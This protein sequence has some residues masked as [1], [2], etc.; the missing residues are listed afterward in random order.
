MNSARSTERGRSGTWRWR[1]I[2]VSDWIN[3]KKDRRKYAAEFFNDFDQRVP[4]SI[5]KLD[6][7]RL[8][9]LFALIFILSS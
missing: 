4:A 2:P 6:K 8:P 3:T 9:C 7:I 1:T 5:K